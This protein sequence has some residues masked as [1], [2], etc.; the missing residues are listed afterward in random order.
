MR[1]LT[2]HL[3]LLTLTALLLSVGI[4]A[5]VK[6]DF[7]EP[8]TGGEPVNIVANTTIAELKTRHITS[9]GYDKITEDL[10]IEGTVVMD[11]RSGNYYKTLVIQDATGGIEVKFNDGYLYN[12]YPVGRKMYIR[13]QDLILTDYNNLVQLTGSTVEQGGQLDDVGLTEAQVRS[14]VVKGSISA[15]PPVP[16]VVNIADINASHISTL[17]Q[18]QNVQ[19]I[20]ADAGKTF[21]DPVTNY[22]L[23][24]TL[25][26]CDGDQIIL[27][28]SGYADFAGELTPTKNGT[29][30]GVLGI[31]GTTLQFYVRDLND[32]D[33][34]TDRCSGVGGELMSISNV[35]ALFSGTTTSAPDNRKI[36]GIVISDRSASNLNGRNLFLQDESAGIVVRFTS[37]HSYNLGDEIEVEVSNEELSEFN[38]LLQVNGVP[39]DNSAALSSGNTVIPRSATVAEI[40]ANF[41]AWESTLVKI[42][43]ATISG[44]GTPLSG[45][46]TVT[47]A[48]GNIAMYTQTYASFAN[49]TTPSGPVTIT[50]IVSDFNGNQI[51]LRNASDIQP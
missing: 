5:C 39:L 30:T 4:T 40:H 50:A 27:R 25:E 24:R 13:C 28:T 48:S 42:S 19:F 15:T 51:I 12:Q 37:N 2:K 29:L 36:K 16:Q 10:I 11:D 34:E 14:K 21:A 3:P 23:N 43:N 9:G 38:G 47:D 8:P 49:M 6:R 18:L 1:L 20:A 31:Y 41:D 44:G 45:G 32:I 46:K 26:D 35:R 17:I 33:M 7:D 22:S